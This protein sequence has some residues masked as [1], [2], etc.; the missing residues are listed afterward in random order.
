M[1]TPIPISTTI[2][3]GHNIRGYA[4]IT[5]MMRSNLFMRT[6]LQLCPMQKSASITLLPRLIWGK[7][8]TLLFAGPW[9]G[10]MVAVAFMAK[11]LVHPS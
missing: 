3:S 11:R 9:R 8:S 6:F 1:K 2:V 10:I 7:P 4:T 5:A